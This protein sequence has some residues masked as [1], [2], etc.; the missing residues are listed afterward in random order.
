M[1]E[2]LKLS[3]GVNRPPKME[4]MIGSGSIFKGNIHSTGAVRVDGKVE[5]NIM[6]CPH[7]IIG[8]T[9]EISGDI[10]AQ[11]VTIGGKVTGNIISTTLEILKNAEIY[12]DVQTQNI[13]IAEGATFQGHSAMGKHKHVI[14]MDMVSGSNR[15][16]A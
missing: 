3:K 12:G 4:T 14:E 8:A 2:K 13:T 9:G 11:T 15:E 5:G 16:L 6:E 7:L 1:F 10:Y